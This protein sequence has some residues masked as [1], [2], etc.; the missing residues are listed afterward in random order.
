MLALLVVVVTSVMV[1][2]TVVVV[3]EAQYRHTRQSTSTVTARTHDGFLGTL[4][5]LG[6]YHRIRRE[7]VVSD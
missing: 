3:V 5:T 6:T 7:R 4:L 1:V 2:V